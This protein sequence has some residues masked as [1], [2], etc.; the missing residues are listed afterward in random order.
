MYSFSNIEPDMAAHECEPLSRIRAFRNGL[1][2]LFVQSFRDFSGPF[3][4]RRLHH[5]RFEDCMMANQRYIL[6]TCVGI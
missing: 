3:A 4:A 1:V 2:L 6:M 5:A